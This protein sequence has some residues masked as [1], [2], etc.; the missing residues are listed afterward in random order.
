MLTLLYSPVSIHVHNSSLIV[1]RKVANIISNIIVCVSCTG[2]SISLDS[3]LPNSTSQLNSH[4]YRHSNAFNSSSSYNPSQCRPDCKW[5]HHRNCPCIHSNNNRN[6]QLYLYSLISLN[7]DSILILFYW[8]KAIFNTH[9]FQY[10]SVDLIKFAWTT[11][12]VTALVY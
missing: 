12:K 1:Q 10:K 3:P 2:Q 11:F 8:E 7:F 4:I 5:A 9:F 6:R